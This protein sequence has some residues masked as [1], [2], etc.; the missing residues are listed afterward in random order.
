MYGPVRTVVWA[1][2]R[3]NSPSDPITYTTGVD[4]DRRGELIRNHRLFLSVGHDEYWSAGQRRNVEAARDAGVNLGFFSGNEVFW[5]TRWEPSIATGGEPSGEPYRTLV[6]YKETHAN[7]KIDPLAEV[8]TG[9]W[10]DSRPFNPEGTQPENA[11]TGTIFTVNAWRNDPLIVPAEYAQLRFWRNTKVAEL[12]PGERAVLLKGLLG[13]EWDEDLDNGFRPPGLFRLSETTI[14]NVPY[15]QDCGSV[16]DSGSA[17]HHLTL[18]RHA[19]GALV[20]GAGTVQWAW[21]LDAHHD[22][23]TGVPPERVNENTTR[24][25]V[26]PNGPDPVI[27]Q[28]TVNL[29]ADMGVQPATLAADLVAATAA[30]DHRPSVSTITVPADGASLDVAAMRIA[31]Q[32]HASGACVAAVEVSVDGGT[33]WH[34]ANGRQ[35]WHYDWTPAEAGRYTIL[36]RAVDDSGYLEQA[37]SAVTVQLDAQGG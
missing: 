24:V 26:D 20:F 7:A 17:T 15:V 2:G 23:E 8:W 32:A 27:R 36:C 10:R 14:D 29:F 3:G 19:S 5:K 25:G 21:G 28:A 33:T 4:S 37:Q 18:Y 6:T 35:A 31:G 22:T 16:F 12:Q 1:D 11:L 13:H 9:T 30:D 34:P